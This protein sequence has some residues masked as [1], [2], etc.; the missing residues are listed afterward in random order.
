MNVMKSL[1]E[2][3]SHYLF[4]LLTVAAATIIF[5]A[6]RGYFAKGQWP[7]LYLLIV[8][9]VAIY[10]GVWPAI[11]ASILSFFAWNYFFL[12]PYH[13]F[14]IDDPKD[15]ISLITFLVVG[16]I[17]GMQTGRLRE[18]E[19]KIAQA[20]ALREADRL[21]TIFVSSVSHGLKTPLASVIAT[22]SNL[23]EKDIGWQ[24]GQVRAELAAIR[25]DLDNLSNSINSLVDL[26]RLESLAWLP[27]K[28]WFG[29]GEIIGTTLSR[30]AAKQRVRVTVALPD[31]LPEIEMD[32]EQIARM[33]QN[34]IENALVYSGD[35][36][37]VKISA[38]YNAREVIVSIEDQGPGIPSE[39]RA[40]I[41]DKFYRGAQASALPSGTGLGLAIAQEIVRSHGGR[42][43]VEDATP[44]GA[45]LMISLPTGV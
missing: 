25:D 12:P 41:F 31:D 11:L 5:F 37:P 28:N 44:H 13:T 22:V 15:W 4:A 29:L 14:M 26:S 1:L 23:L 27:Q 39:E 40:K 34:I 3:S 21:K 38:R 10:G 16:V 6:G 30:L 2:R 43:W 45:R 42:I 20:D 9:I 17:M 33:L 24:E 7:L 35:D 36:R 18:R 19:Q 8:V 32:F